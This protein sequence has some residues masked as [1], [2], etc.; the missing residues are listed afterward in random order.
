MGPA[1][2]ARNFARA[3]AT[4]TLEF[5]FSHM[6]FRIEDVPLRK[7]LT[8]MRTSVNTARRSPRVPSY[9]VQL[10]VETS[11]TCG[12][13]CPLCPTGAGETERANRVM[14]FPMFRKLIDEVGDH[15]VIALM[16]LWGEPF[17]NRKLC[18][19]ISY[20]H[21]K[22]MATFTSTNGQH[23]DSDEDADRLVASGLDNLIVSLDGG[24][25]ETYARY[26]EGG[27]IGKVMRTLE[28]IRRAKDR[29]GMETPLVNVQTVVTREN[30]HELPQVEQIARR[31]G[32]NMLSKVVTRFPGFS[33]DE[34]RAHFTPD[35]PLYQGT[36]Y[37]KADNS[38]MP[39][40]EYQCPRPWNRMT[41]TVDGVLVPCEHDYNGRGSMGQAADGTSFMQVW[42]GAQAEAFRRRFLDDKS[43]FD[44][45]RDCT[46]AGKLPTECTVMQRLR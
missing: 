16:W 46:F 33:T 21:G 25:Q 34:M 15:A 27:N 6:P 22:K 8:I 43:V 23:M 29:L 28:L 44:F 2:K 39:I 18:D 4:R 1:R 5:E 17:M 38:R 32:A 26:R 41:V 7:L 36:R 37:D 35:N 42:R 24:T 40:E 20:A 10:H 9:P 14:P 45:C 3:L 12:L 19:M 11:A 30:E 31:Y 13:H